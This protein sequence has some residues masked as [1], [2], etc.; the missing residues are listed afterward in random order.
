MKLGGELQALGIDSGVLYWPTLSRTGDRLAY[1]KRRVDVNIYRMDG[2]GPEG[3]PRPYGE[4]HVAAVVD[5]TATD[6]EPTLSPD[7]R[8]LA[9][10]SDRLGY[11]EIHVADADGSRQVALTSMGPTAMGSPRWSPDN[12]TIVFDRYENGHSSIYTIS[13]G[14][15]KP[16]RVTEGEFRDIRPSYSRDGKWIYF[17]SNRSGRIEVW[18]VAASGG[19]LQQV[20]QNSGNEAFESP[21]GQ[22]LYYTNSQGLWSLPVAGGEP[23]LVLNDSVFLLYALAGRSIYYAV[24]NPTALWVLR[25][26]TGR[27]FEY[28]RFP[29]EGIG[30]D[31][32][33]VFSVSPDE[34]TIFFSRTDRLESDLM[35]VENFR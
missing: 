6:R 24:R 32:G 26:D 20:T 9:F 31:G 19:A 3:G 25:T 17:S 2:P 8:H 23:K 10:N 14:G 1:E 29:N 22:L 7:G 33:T 30:L 12:Q 11:Y 21:D 27:K 35:L 15:G 5:S 16:R 4:C 28:V 18:K 34:R 13:S